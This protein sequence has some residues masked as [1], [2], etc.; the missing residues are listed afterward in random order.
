[1]KQD[2]SERLTEALFLNT[3]ILLYG[4]SILWLLFPQWLFLETA[5]LLGFLCTKMSSIYR[6]RYK[7]LPMN[8]WSA[9]RNPMYLSRLEENGQTGSRL[10]ERNCC[11]IDNSLP[12][13]WDQTRH[14]I[15]NNMW[16]N[17]SRWP[18]K[19]AV[20]PSRSPKLDS[21]VSFIQSAIFQF[22]WPEYIRNIL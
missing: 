18:R 7:K 6:E 20:L 4:L 19:V 2:Y 13:W 11:S 16:S 10:Q 21:Y 8:S 14:N 12:P 5:D 1:M 3:L 15:L 17:D 22:R 9:S